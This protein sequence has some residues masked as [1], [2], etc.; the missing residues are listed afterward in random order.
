EQIGAP[1]VDMS[2]PGRTRGS[3]A[4]PSDVDAMWRDRGRLR[5]IRVRLTFGMLVP[6]VAL[7]AVSAI[8]GFW[9][10]GTE[11]RVPATLVLVLAALL[12]PPSRA[13]RAAHIL[14]HARAIAAERPQLTALNNRARLD[15]MLD[16]LTGL[17]NHRAFQEE[18]ARQLEGVSRDG[19]S[20]ALMLI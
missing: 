1:A 13:F 8:Q 10:G 5:T 7:M 6:F 2:E 15:A 11:A 20:V 18:L 17:G 9:P 4:A 16:G 19:Q 12:L 14:R 3:M